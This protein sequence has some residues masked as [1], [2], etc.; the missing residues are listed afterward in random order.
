VCVCVCVWQHARLVRS[1][2]DSKDRETDMLIQL[3]RM[4]ESL[5]F[6]ALK[7]QVAT[8]VIRDDEQ[9]IASLRKDCGEVKK[10]SVISGQKEADAS[11]LVESLRVE[12]ST[13][14]RQMREKTDEASSLYATT[15]VALSVSDAEVDHMMAKMMGGAGGGG[16]GGRPVTQSSQYDESGQMQRLKPRGIT[17]FQDWK[18]QN[19]IWSPDI[20]TKDAF[21]AE[22]VRRSRGEGEAPQAVLGMLDEAFRNMK[23]PGGARHSKRPPSTPFAS[24]VGASRAR[25]SGSSGGGNGGGGELRAVTAG[26]QGRSASTPQLSSRDLLSQKFPGISKI[27]QRVATKQQVGRGEIDD[28][29]F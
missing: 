6:S 22:K 17:P 18:L 3:R 23:S 24:A 12:V 13:L 1:L 28:N 10:L 4:K 11:N 14:K 25:T 26:M 20:P 2:L 9:I 8:K 15:S 16:G 27:R 29:P 5:V 19:Y 7:L 21:D